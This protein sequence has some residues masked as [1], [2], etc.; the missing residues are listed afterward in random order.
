MLLQDVAQPKITGH[1]RI[2]EEE[3]GKVLLDK[4]NDIHAENFSLALATA[5]ANSG[6]TI[7]TLCFGNG[8][9]RVNASNEFLYQTPNILN[10]AANLKSQTYSKVIDQH[11]SDNPDP[12][13]NYINVTHGD[14]NNYTDILCH[15]TLEKSEPAAQ[16]VVSSS[17]DIISEYTFNEVGLK[18][19]E[20]DLIT[21]LCFYPISKNS[22]IVLVFNYLLRIKV[23]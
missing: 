7:K 6:G 13:R 3:S 14:G 17:T 23:V 19:T 11:S 9:V 4:H 10:R 1:L 5:L 16:N 12:T 22:N 8:G 18:T 20:G 2:Y 21:H 15:C